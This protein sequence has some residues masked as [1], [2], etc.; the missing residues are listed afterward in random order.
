MRST[1]RTIHI[2]EV[3]LTFFAAFR[4]FISRNSLN[5]DILT[6]IPHPISDITKIH[7]LENSLQ[8][9]PQ[10]D[11]PIGN[12]KSLNTGVASR[13]YNNLVQYLSDQYSS[14]SPDTPSRGGKAFGATDDPGKSTQGQGKKRKRNRGKGGK[15]NGG[16]KG[17]D[18][19]C[20]QQQQQAPQAH[21]VTAPAHLPQEPE[22][23]N[24]RLKSQPPWS[25][26]CINGQP[27]PLPFPQQDPTPA[28]N[29][30]FERPPIEFTAWCTYGYNT[31]HNGC[32]VHIRVQRPSSLLRGPSPLRR[33]L[34][35]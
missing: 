23:R 17:N 28:P 22:Y 16:G 21:A 15:G 13:S 7:W 9:C 35:G 10:F 5:H 19:K 2:K 24:Q 32:V 25:V 11:I 26:N 8:R 14:L 33:Q 1:L 27:D 18:P 29:D 3:L 12:W 6:K 20:Q 34:R 4:D 30:E 31:T